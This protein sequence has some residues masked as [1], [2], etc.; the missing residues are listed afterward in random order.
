MASRVCLCLSPLRIRIRI[1]ITHTHTLAESP[2]WLLRRRR[3]AERETHLMRLSCG[4]VCAGRIYAYAYAR[5]VFAKSS[6]SLR[7]VFAKSSRPHLRLRPPARRSIRFP[8]VGT[9][10]WH[11]PAHPILGS[12]FLVK[13]RAEAGAGRGVTWES[14]KTLILLTPGAKPKMKIAADS[15]HADTLAAELPRKNLVWSEGGPCH[16]HAV[17]HETGSSHN[18][19]AEEIGGI[20]A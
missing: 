8:S 16:N 15:S 18:L 7:Q 6:P 3:L 12:P 13:P 4:L 9:H 20:H 2:R 19:A 11:S 17:L 5:Q 14:T 1:R 10:L